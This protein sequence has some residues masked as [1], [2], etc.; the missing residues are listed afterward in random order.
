MSTVVPEFVKMDLLNVNVT[1]RMELIWQIGIKLNQLFF[2]VLRITAMK[3]LVL[4]ENVKIRS[5]NTNVFVT[6]DIKL[7][8]LSKDTASISTNVPFRTAANMETAET[9]L[10]VSNATATTDTPSSMPNVSIIVIL[11]GNV[12]SVLVKI[13]E[14]ISNVNVLL[15]PDMTR[16][17]I[18]VSI[19]TNVK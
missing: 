4:M 18:N 5:R 12:A 19:L 11:K 3:L 15:A 14:S 8:K 6:K 1:V 16:N 10:A 17:K 9:R 7:M 2:L 13:L